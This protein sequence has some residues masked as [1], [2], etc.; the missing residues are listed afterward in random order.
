MKYLEERAGKVESLLWRAP[1]DCIY[2]SLNVFSSS[3]SDLL[4][5]LHIQRLFRRI[6]DAG[7]WRKDKQAKAIR[8]RWQRADMVRCHLFFFLCCCC[9][10]CE[11][12]EKSKG[13]LAVVYTT[14]STTQK[15]VYIRPVERR[16]LWVWSN[17]ALPPNLS[18]PLPLYR[19]FIITQLRLML[20][21]FNGRRIGRC[22]YDNAAKPAYR[23]TRQSS[24]LSFYEPICIDIWF[25]DNRRIPPFCCC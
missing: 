6:L 23:L 4:K 17:E 24:L 25:P 14:G 5:G 21:G 8:R 13:C 1:G 9:C 7:V 16:G 10:C 12:V 15:C 22:L 11:V 19:L 20:L 3:S 18:T 2:I